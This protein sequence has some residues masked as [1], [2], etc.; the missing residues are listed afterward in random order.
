[1]VESA[2]VASVMAPTVP[3][4]KGSPRCC[5][6]S[7]PQTWQAEHSTADLQTQRAKH[8]AARRLAACPSAEAGAWLAVAPA[9]AV[10][11]AM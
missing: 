8:S 5:S 1:M 10:I 6:V 7:E 4:L 11:V 9:V 3:V 2:S